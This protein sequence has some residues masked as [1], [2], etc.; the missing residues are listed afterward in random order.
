M[1][2]DHLRTYL[3]TQSAITNITS[4][5]YPI[6]LP[7]RPTYPAIVYEESDHYEEETFDGQE[8]FT[9]SDYIYHAW[10][11]TYA[12]AR[13]LSDAIRTTLKNFVGKANT[14]YIGHTILTAGPETVYEHETSAYRVSQTFTFTHKE[15]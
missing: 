13:T 7:S 5:I 11:Q 12:E 3:L 14:I 15:G 6:H 4:N 8:G 10:A 9:D 2:G 1:I